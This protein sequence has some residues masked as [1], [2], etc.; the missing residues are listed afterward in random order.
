MQK[1]DLS[2]LPQG[3]I[4]PIIRC[5]QG[6]VGR[7]F[8]VE[9]YSEDMSAKYVLDGT[10]KLTVEGHKPDRNFFSYDLPSTTG[11]I[12]TVYYTGTDDSRH[13]S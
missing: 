8:Q 11:S 12:I 3:G 10:E 7:Q 4:N 1:I 5:S 6:D 13:V 2:I 9:L